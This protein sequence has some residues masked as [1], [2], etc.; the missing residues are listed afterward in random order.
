ML[1][2]RIMIIL[3]EHPLSPFAQK[4]K[5]ALAEKD[6]KFE[7]RMPDLFSGGDAEF[8][9]ANPRREVPAL[10]VGDQTE[11]FDST[12][13]L[14]YIEDRWPHPPLLPSL[15]AERARARMIEE[16]CDTY[17]EAINW[18]VFEIT[19]FGRAAGDLAAKL[20]ARAAEQTAGVNA[21][22]ERH[23]GSAPYFNGESFGWA[24]LSVVPMV[25]A[26][27]MT[28]RPPTPKSRLAAWL[29]IVGARPSVAHVM[30]QATDSLGG[31]MESVAQ[32]IESGQFVREYRDHRLEW[33]MRS[34]GAEIVR[35]GMEKKNIRFSHE[36][37]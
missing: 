16:V 36:L 27:A 12:I 34:G 20:L 8:A 22:L 11:I 29:E 18:A 3:Y 31:G 21:Y 23:L 37:E 5:I 33:M 7:S 26:A 30:K 19:A 28:G 10:V 35:E 32:L 13:I 24:D 6:V 17:Y 14:E 9:K 25:T 15:P 4:V 2:S 1:Y